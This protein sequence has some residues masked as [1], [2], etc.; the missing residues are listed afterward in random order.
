MRISH[1]RALCRGIAVCLLMV[2]L[3]FVAVGFFLPGMYDDSVY[4]L[5]IGISIWVVSIGVGAW[6][7]VRHSRNIDM[8]KE[9]H[10]D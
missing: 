9:G 4:S 5:I 2:S 7:V 8:W 1:T 10:D 6:Q 3:L